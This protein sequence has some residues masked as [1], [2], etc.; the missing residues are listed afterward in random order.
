MIKILRLFAFVLSSMGWWEIIRKRSN[1]NIY[2]I[3][4]LT[5]AL[6]VTV[7]FLCGLFNLL[8]EG[9]IALFLLGLL[10]LFLAIVPLPAALFYVLPS[11]AL[12]MS[13]AVTQKRYRYVIDVLIV[14]LCVLLWL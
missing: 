5:I 4:G 14:S 12:H 13:V 8:K 9:T 10:F 11:V 7:L 2:F 3:P 1:I 6:Q